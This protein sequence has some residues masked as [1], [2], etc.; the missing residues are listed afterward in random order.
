MCTF[1]LSAVQPSV[2]PI[3]SVFPIGSEAVFTCVT[4]DATTYYSSWIVN[5]PDGPFDTYDEATLLQSKGIFLEK[6][7]TH[8]VL[9]V[10]ASLENNGTSFYCREI[11]VDGPLFSDEIILIAIGIYCM[12][13]ILSTSHTLSAP[14]PSPKLH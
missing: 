7:N 5:S 8:L 6:N 2:S 3:N 1:L 10:L 12:H 4:S 9:S 14:P 13:I 11:H